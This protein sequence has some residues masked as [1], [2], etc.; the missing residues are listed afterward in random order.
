[1][2]LGDRRFF[3]PKRRLLFGHRLTHSS[4]FAAALESGL[5][6]DGQRIGSGPGG[7]LHFARL[8]VAASRVERQTR[9]AL[10]FRM[11]SIQKNHLGSS[12]WLASVHP[13]GCCATVA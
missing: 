12:S 5:L 7:A 2:Q 11:G 8:N 13:V 4:M 3:E 10:V 6:Q 9:Q 1:M